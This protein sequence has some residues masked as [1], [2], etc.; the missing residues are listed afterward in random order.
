MENKDLPKPQYDPTYPDFFA[1]SKYKI[2]CAIYGKAYSGA[3]TD[4]GEGLAHLVYQPDDFEEIY[5]HQPIVIADPGV[6]ADNAS[7]AQI[8]NKNEKKILYRLQQTGKPIVRAVSL[9]GL[10]K[11]FKDQLEV[12]HSMD[13]LELNDAFS[14]LEAANTVKP[15]DIK[16]LQKRMTTA[17]ARD[18]KIEAHA[19]QQLQSFAYLESAGQA[20][21][22]MEA[23]ELMWKSY[24]STP[25]DKLDFNG[26][27]SSYLR[28]WPQLD[29]QTPINFAAA[30]IVY[31]NTLLPA[32]R[33]AN[34]V[35]RMAF[36]A[37]EV[38]DAVIVQP[39]AAAA[40]AVTLPPKKQQQAGG[41]RGVAGARGGNG[42]GAPAAAAAAVPPGK[43]R[44]YCY[45]CGVPEIPRMR[46]YSNNCRTPNPDHNWDA[47]FNNQMGGKAVE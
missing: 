25:A 1:L 14:Q 41:H 31:V 47:T 40:A 38:P 19:A 22:P 10:P 26:F 28:Q 11:R 43:P 3:Y 23:V 24:T 13:H 37:Q 36:A 9:D 7:A 42:G 30:I 20:P 44:Y 15:A 16:L 32:E 4:D 27:M 35:R 18:V 45:S 6:H 8:A 39:I 33:E 2:G 12:N 34:N 29:D 46:H 21:A 5:G 17:W